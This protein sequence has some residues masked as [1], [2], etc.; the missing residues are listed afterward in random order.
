[1]HVEKS[2]LALHGFTI[3]CSGSPILASIEPNQKSESWIPVAKDLGCRLGSLIRRGNK[4]RHNNKEINSLQSDGHS[5]C[6]ISDGRNIGVFNEVSFKQGRTERVSCQKFVFCYLLESA[7]LI[8]MMRR[9]LTNIWSIAI[10]FS[11]MYRIM[12]DEM[13]DLC[14][15]YHTKEVGYFDMWYPV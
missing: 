8:A 11:Y 5:L 9:R 10:P 6:L 4:Q 7:R 1:M 2:C 13:G 15:R 12:Q 3:E 14:D